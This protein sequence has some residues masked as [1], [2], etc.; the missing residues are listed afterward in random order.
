MGCIDTVKT[1]IGAII[2][3]D[4]LIS[5]GSIQHIVDGPLNTEESDRCLLLFPKDNQS[6]LGSEDQSRPLLREIRTQGLESVCNR[7]N[8][9]QLYEARTSISTF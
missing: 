5:K 4:N 1:R 2:T 8:E 3:S 9:N 6:K 7:L